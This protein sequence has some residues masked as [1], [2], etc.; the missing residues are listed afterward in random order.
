MKPIY[1]FT[2]VV[3][4]GAMLFTSCKKSSTD[5]DE[6]ET[7]YQLS[8][9]ASVSDYLVEDVSD[10]KDEALLDKDL[11]GTFGP[12]TPAETNGILGCATVTVTPLSGFPKTIL[13]DFGT[14]CTDSFGI[15]R[16]GKIQIVI[17]DSVRRTGSTAVTTF[18]DYFVNLFKIEGTITWT[19][20]ST[21]GAKSWRRE[22]ANGKITGPTGR[23]WLHTSIREVRQTEGVSTPRNLRDDEFSITGHGS[24]TNPAGEVRTHSI[25]TALQKKVICRNIDKG[26][27]RF[28]GPHHYAVLDYGN[29]VCDNDATIS[30]DGGT[31]RHITLR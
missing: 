20:T 19:N 23:Y 2:L 17:S 8:T 12:T 22:V 31:P 13:I 28:D 29:G 21:A 25:L 1:L 24:I 27:I 3:L 26:T 4:S 10:V 15:T 30:I 5:T 14:G 16:K 7:S 11:M 9:D 6:I 18:Q